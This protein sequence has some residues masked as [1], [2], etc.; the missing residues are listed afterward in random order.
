MYVPEPFRVADRGPILDLMDA[1]PFV[2]LVTPDASD[3]MISH[4]PLLLDRS[5]DAWG[6]LSGH[7]A[8]ANPHWKRLDGERECVAIFQGP[9]AYVSPAWYEDGP[10]VPTWN[11]AVVHAY[12]RP[13]CVDDPA[14]TTAH[15]DALIARYEA[16]G[17]DVP[18]A[19]RRGLQKGIVGFTFEIER[20]ESKF[21]LGQNKSSADRAGTVRALD[22][23]GATD[24]AAWTRRITEA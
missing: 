1:F 13:I 2:A 14:H 10:A 24:L 17:L 6:R 11:Y 20:L 7:V 23:T 3:V 8:R 21:K 12:G 5:D 19:F 18:D 9:H 15:L 16:G 4:V 22:E